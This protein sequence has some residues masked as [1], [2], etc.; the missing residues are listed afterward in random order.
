MNRQKAKALRN[1]IRKML[2]TEK[3]FKELGFTF[4]FDA[5]SACEILDRIVER[6]KTTTRNSYIALWFAANGFKVAKF[7]SVPSTRYTI[8]VSR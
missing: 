8:S 2:G 1:N 3:G 6:G 7:Q 5:M 4:Y